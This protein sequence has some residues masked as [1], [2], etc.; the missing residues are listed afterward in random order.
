MPSARKRYP[1][2]ARLTRRCFVLVGVFVLSLAFAATA[3]AAA[4]R[5]HGRTARRHLGRVARR[6]RSRGP[7]TFFVAQN[8]SDSNSGTSPSRPWRTVW[9]VDRASLRAGDSVLFRGGDTFSDTTLMP[10]EG[11]QASGTTGRP[12]TFG[13]YGAGDATITNGIWLGTDAQHPHGPQHL[14]FQD[15]ALGPEQGFQGTGNYISLLRLRIEDMLAPVSRGETAIMTEGSHWVIAGNFIYRAGDSGMLLG[16][17]AGY[18]GAPPGGS[19][20]LVEH[21]TIEHTGLDP[22]LGYGSHGI[23]DKVADA[24]IADNTIADFRDDGVSARYRNAR[25]VGNNISYGGIGIGWYQ[26]D[27]QRGTSRFMFNHIEGTT[28]AGIFVCGVAEACQ[29][30]L[31][32][33]VIA[34]NDLFHTFGDVLNLQPISGRYDVFA[35]Y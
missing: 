26:Y 8:G 18:P 24:T 17:S 30:P 10:G 23:Y 28:E 2:V 29:R 31:G 14:T 22:S 1:R 20:Y 3:Y 12:I 25:I 6:L 32:S 11:F 4:R 16:F 34:H 15:L 19:H 9:R 21:N 13:S 7:L 35:N 33:F 5:H 27:R